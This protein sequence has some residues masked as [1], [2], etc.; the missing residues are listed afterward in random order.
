MYKNKST[1]IEIF[2]WKWYFPFL[3][4]VGHKMKADLKRKNK[5]VKNVGVH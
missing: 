3:E 5:N 1:T 4:I 2:Q